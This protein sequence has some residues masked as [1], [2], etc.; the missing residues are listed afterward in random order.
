MNTAY[1]STEMTLMGLNLFPTHIHL[2]IW[3]QTLKSGRLL[4]WVIETTMDS[5]QANL[6]TNLTVKMSLEIILHLNR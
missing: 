3:I 4:L 6:T 2:E 1:E 5:I